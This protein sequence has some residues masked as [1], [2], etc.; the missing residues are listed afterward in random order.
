MS[1]EDTDA[2]GK[3]EIEQMDREHVFDTWSYQ[4]E[5]SPTEVVHTDGVRFTDAEGNKFIDFSG[6]LMCSNLGHSA[7]R[8][9]KAIAEQASRAE[10]VVALS[11]A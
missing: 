6:Q 8:V 1:R 11:L 5:A 2:E 4:S 3:N 9:E 10:Y 7:K